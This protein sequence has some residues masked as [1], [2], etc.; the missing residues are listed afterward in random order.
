MRCQKFLLSLRL[1]E[2]QRVITIVN[3]LNPVLTKHCYYNNNYFL[4]PVSVVIIITIITIII[5]QRKNNVI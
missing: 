1:I 2:C 5:V 3:N 4:E